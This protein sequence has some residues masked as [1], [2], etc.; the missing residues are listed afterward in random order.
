MMSNV[1]MLNQE[2]EE[3]QLALALSLLEA[4]K[5]RIPKSTMYVL[6]RSLKLDLF[7]HFK[8]NKL[9]DL[10]IKRSSFL[11]WCLSSILLLGRKIICTSKILKKKSTIRGWETSSRPSAPSSRPKW[12]GTR[13]DKAKVSDSSVSPTS[14]KRK[15]QSRK[16]RFL[17]FSAQIIPSVNIRTRNGWF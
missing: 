16:C 11:D 14:K 8:L 4:E 13:A 3:L 10:H 7:V 1:Q 17:L 5:E 9:N 2:E 15:G 6:Q 12:R